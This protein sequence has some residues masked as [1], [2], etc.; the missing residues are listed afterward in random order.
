V[1]RP[2][3]SRGAIRPATGLIDAVDLSSNEGG[4]LV[5][6]CSKA[7]LAG[8][9][10][11]V[12]CAG[13]AVGAE[14]LQALQAHVRDRERAFAKT[15]ADRDHAAF[16]TFVSEEAVFMGATPF[17]GRAAVAE[18]WRRFFETKAAPFAWE[19]ER[20]EVIDS[21]TLAIS[22]GPVFDPAGQRIGTFNSTWRREADGVWRVVIDIGCPPCRCP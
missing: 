16:A 13:F 10:M 14:P 6:R 21:G 7:A 15:M 11:V 18:G 4:C 3:L 2:G 8:A 19:P 22:S 9:V 5:I 12:T 20:V 17:R 1:A